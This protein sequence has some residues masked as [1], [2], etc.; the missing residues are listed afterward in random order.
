MKRASEAANG[1]GWKGKGQNA[2]SR[3]GYYPTGIIGLTSCENA[4]LAVGYSMS[5][6]FVR[7][8]DFDDLPELPPPSSGLPPGAKNY[9]TAGGAE[10]LREELNRLLD[11]ERPGVAA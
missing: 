6:A 5:K 4:V 8:S 7:E 10:R 3:N 2:R 9:M 11:K 1:G